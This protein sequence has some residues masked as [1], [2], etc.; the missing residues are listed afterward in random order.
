LS[1]YKRIY[2]EDYKPFEYDITNVDLWIDFFD[3]KTI[4]RS[5]LVVKSKE[6]DSFLPLVLKGEELDTLSIL[7]DSRPAM[8]KEFEL[9]DGELLIY[10]S[11]NDFSIETV[12]EIHP[13]K[14]TSLE[15]IYKSDGF[16]CSQCEAE[17]FR[18]ITWHPDRPDVLSEFSCTVSGD[19]IK[20]PVLLSNGNPVNKGIFADGRHFVKWHDPFL[21][22]SYLFAVVA[23][24]LYCV[25]DN[26]KTMS[27]KNVVLRLF[28]EPENKEKCFHAINSLKK[29]MKWDEDVFSREYDLDIYMIV[30]VRAFNMGAMENKGLNIFNSNYVLADEKTGTDDDFFNIE[31]VVAHEYFHNWTGNRITLANW[32]QLSLKEGLTVFRDQ[33]FSSEQGYGPVSRIKDVRILKSRQFSEDAGPFSHPV[34]PESYIEMNNFYTA[35]VYEKGAE[36]IRM[37]Y[38]WLGRDEFLKGMNLYFDTND[39]KAVTCED[40]ID[41]MSKSSDQDLFKFMRWYE[42]SGTPCLKFDFEFNDLENSLKITAY[43]ETNETTGQKEKLPLP[44]PVRTAFFDENGN[45]LEFKVKGDDESKKETVFLLLDSKN[46]FVVSGI[47]KKPVPS[48]LR[49]FSAPVRF[50][51]GYSLEDDIFLMSHDT[52]YFNRWDAS[53]RVIFGTIENIYNLMEKN[54][55]PFLDEKFYKGFSFIINDSYCDKSVIGEILTLPS[56]SDICQELFNSKIK[57]NPKTLKKS[58]FFVATKLA[59]KFESNFLSLVKENMGEKYVFSKN[60]MSKRKLKNSALMFLSKLDYSD[61][62]YDLYKKAD[63]MTDLTLCLKALVSYENEKSNLA[64]N[65]FYEKWKND[66]VVMDKWFAVQAQSSGSNTFENVLSLLDHPLFSIK[67]PNRVRSLIGVYANN[68]QAF[69][70]KDGKGYDFLSDHILKL[71]KINPQIGAR[72]VSYLSNYKNFDSETSLMMKESLLRIYN[73]KNLSKDVFEMVS[74]AL[75]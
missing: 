14:N 50:D 42:Q 22:P 12:C 45:Q 6:K 27:G 66:A 15:G 13:E 60:E 30:A 49:G 62:I 74:R 4:V 26:Y 5:K 67:N 11:K 36:I 41:A 24:D 31:S 46:E 71:S 38:N 25:E 51:C 75:A 23:G 17:G 20:Y 2:L 7:I 58:S 53:Q 72:L 18:K 44:V 63:N 43:Q 64:L 61:F 34:R 3:D 73:T 10:P 29:A 68:F 52:D 48:V 40:F 32:F 8:K 55:E 39:L 21:K 9:K 1:E 57:V 37:I 33:L 69:H 16:F 56:D 47:N 35:T 19:F 59:E 54:H 28:T 70:R 65:D